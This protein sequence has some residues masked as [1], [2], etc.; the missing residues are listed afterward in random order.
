MSRSIKLNDSE[1]ISVAQTGDPVAIEA[2]LRC[3]GPRIY[4]ICRRLA[5]D[6][7]DVEEVYQDTLLDMVRHLPRFRGESGLLT[8]AYTIARTQWNR[9]RRRKGAAWSRRNIDTEIGTVANRLI[10]PGQLPED[11]LFAGQLRQEIES[12]LDGLSD[13]DRQILLLRDLERVLRARGC[14]PHGPDRAG[15]QDPSAP[16]AHLRAGRPAASIPVSGQLGRPCGVAADR[17]GQIF[18]LAR[19]RAHRFATDPRAM[20]PIDTT[21]DD[22]TLELA[23][24]RPAHALGHGAA[25]W[26]LAGLAPLVAAGAYFGSR[27]TLEHGPG[28]RAT[29]AGVLEQEER[30]TASR[31]YTIPDQVDAPSTA[32][33]EVQ[34]PVFAAVVA[35]EEVVSKR[36]R[37]I[38]SR[39]ATSARVLPDP[40]AE[41]SQERVPL[42]DVGADEPNEGTGGSTSDLPLGR[43]AEASSPPPKTVPVDAADNPERQDST[44]ADQGQDL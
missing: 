41:S 43:E 35:E 27:I 14:G 3:Y 12:V 20:K 38:R 24:A 4:R 10:D 17:A 1:L 32:R 6:V 36:T 39:G 44:D 23:D 11:Q 22:L 7:D 25:V 21:G 5:S 18:D 33:A 15:G 2:L 29:E 31:G 19:G 28:V 26:V 40:E 37:A 16:R 34:P 8:W 9:R 13:I 30:V 42:E